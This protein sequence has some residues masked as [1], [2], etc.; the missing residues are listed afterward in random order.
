M[1]NLLKSAI[2]VLLLSTVAFLWGYEYVD[3]HRLAGI[4]A[5]FGAKDPTYT[6]ASWAM[7]LG[8]LAFLI[9]VGLLIGGIATKDKLSGFPKTYLQQQRRNPVIFSQFCSDC[10]NK[11]QTDDT[12]CPNCGKKIE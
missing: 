10:G 5:M 4:G 9:G 11:L 2:I 12:F 1:S 3:S 6:I 8:V 7:I